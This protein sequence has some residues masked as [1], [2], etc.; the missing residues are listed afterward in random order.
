MK[1]LMLDHFINNY[2]CM[3]LMKIVIIITNQSTLFLFFE[4]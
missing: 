4:D 1:N 2:K 3:K